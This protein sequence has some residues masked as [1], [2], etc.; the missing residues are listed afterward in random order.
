MSQERKASPRPLPAHVRRMLA[1]YREAEDIPDDARDRIW[2]RLQADEDEALLAEPRTSAPPWLWPV[3]AIAVTV[4]LVWAVRSW[5]ER[6]VSIAEQAEPSEAVDRPVAASPG[7]SVKARP[8]PPRPLS[9]TGEPTSKPETLAAPPGESTPPQRPAPSRTVRPKTESQAAPDP[10]DA[11]AK[12]RALV[13]GAWTALTAQ[14][15]QEALRRV[16]EHRRDFPE[17]LLVPE[18]AAVEAAALCSLNPERGAELAAAFVQAHPG[19][20]LVSRVERACAQKK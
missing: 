5:S 12:E 1:Q 17:G 8:A 9:P 18:R 10:G 15:P 11:L 14:K 6:A 2:A 3:A 16:D 19:S 7:G 20:P 13:Q 4:L